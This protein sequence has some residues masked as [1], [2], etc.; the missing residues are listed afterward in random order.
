MILYTDNQFSTIFESIYLWYHS[1]KC[2][3][4]DFLFPIL[5]RPFVYLYLQ[6]YCSSHNKH[7]ILCQFKLIKHYNVLI[8]IQEGNYK[9]IQQLEQRVPQGKQFK[10]GKT[11]WNKYEV[12]L[13]AWVLALIWRRD[14]GTTFSNSLQPWLFHHV[15]ESH[16]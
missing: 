13:L 15:K 10:S 5:S 1:K 7:L 2:M 14:T 3:R 12:T 8:L 16:Q 4:H 6:A 11:I 9:Y